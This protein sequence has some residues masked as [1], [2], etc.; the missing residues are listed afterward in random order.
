M[1]KAESGKTMPRT[2]KRRPLAEDERY[3]P[4]GRRVK[5]KRPS[6]GSNH[7]RRPRNIVGDFT[8]NNELLIY[9]DL[10]RDDGISNVV[11]TEQVKKA[12]ALANESGNPKV[13]TDREYSQDFLKSLI[14]R[15]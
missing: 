13:W 15:T 5:R 4:W 9:M 14:P 6:Y 11:S 1:Q 7:F 3:D 8:G 2:E 10:N 12:Q